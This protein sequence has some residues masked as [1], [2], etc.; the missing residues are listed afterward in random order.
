MV[1]PTA[2]TAVSLALLT[3][4]ESIKF[5]KKTNN[6]G[7]MVAEADRM[8]KVRFPNQKF[9]RFMNITQ[10]MIF[11]NNMEYSCQNGIVPIEG[12]FYFQLF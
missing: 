10:L 11:S 8:T 4:S 1:T 6:V 3:I 5:V 7:G 9:R 2:A 12:A